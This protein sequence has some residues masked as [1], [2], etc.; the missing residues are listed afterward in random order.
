LNNEKDSKTNFQL[1]SLP[2]TIITEVGLAVGEH[3]GIK[4]IGKYLRSRPYK[5]YP[6]TNLIRPQPIKWGVTR[7]L[8]QGKP[9][10]FKLFGRIPVVGL[11]IDL[12]TP[13]DT[14]MSDSEEKRLLRKE[15]PGRG[16]KIPEIEIRSIKYPDGVIYLPKSN[17]YIIPPSE[18]T[19]QKPI[20][21]GID[22]PHRMSHTIRSGDRIWY[23]SDD[24]GYTNRK[25]FTEDVCKLNPG[26]DFGLLKPGQIITVPSKIKTPELSTPYA[27]RIHQSQKASTQPRSQ[28]IIS[29][30]SDKVISA[31]KDFVRSEQKHNTISFSP[32][33]TSLPD[34]FKGLK[35][36]PMSQNASYSLVSFRPMQTSPSPGSLKWYAQGLR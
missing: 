18:I 7:F 27:L 21:P 32:M 15:G 33:Q 26:I 2:H 11:L 20:D 35:V 34:A 30:T 4:K 23:L 3:Y 14:I 24:Y 10:S 25:K 19:H 36:M 9:L 13:S 1:G 31:W 5:F 8:E 17:K 16:L 22:A 29:P 6:G 12:F 28:G